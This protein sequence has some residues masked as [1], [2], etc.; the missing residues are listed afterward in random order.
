MLFGQRRSATGIAGTERSGL[1]RE[2]DGGVLFLDEIDALEPDAQALLQQAIE[3]GRYYP[4]G[5]DAEATSRFQVI[6]SAT[7]DLGRLVAMGRLRPDLFALL[8]QWTFD[9][10]PLRDRRGDIAANI[11]HQRAQA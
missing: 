6:A 4:L 9:L 3:T 11:S 1:L 7:G 2:A 10:P 5:S 8:H